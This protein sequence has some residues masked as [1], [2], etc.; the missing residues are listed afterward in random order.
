MPQRGA[1]IGLG[2]IDPASGL[3]DTSPGWL[4]AGDLVIVP[5]SIAEGWQSQEG[6]VWPLP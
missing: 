5:G 3:C 2:N 1:V 6:F 4:I